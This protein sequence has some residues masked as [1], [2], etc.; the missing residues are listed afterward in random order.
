MRDT[1]LAGQPIQ[2]GD[3]LILA[4]AAANADPRVHADDMWLEH[5]NRSHLA[6]ST[7]PHVCP[8]HIPARIIARAAVETVL[9]MLPEIRLAVPADDVGLIPSPWTRCPASL[10]VTFT[11]TAPRTQSRSR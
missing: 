5:G 2:R 4:L 3:A 1:E 7:G 11:I 8:A 6:W 10:P 9:H